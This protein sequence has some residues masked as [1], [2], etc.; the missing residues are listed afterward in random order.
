M[1]CTSGCVFLSN[2]LFISVIIR[3]NKTETSR[4]V[5]DPSIINV[6]CFYVCNKKYL[7]E[8]FLYVTTSCCVF[9]YNQSDLHAMV[10]KTKLHLCLCSPVFL[11]SLYLSDIRHTYT[12]PWWLTFFFLH[13]THSCSCPWGRF[14]TSP[15]T[16]GQ[17]MMTWCKLLQSSHWMAWSINPAALQ[18]RI[19]HRHREP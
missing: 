5:V 8:I 17:M 18:C 14:I 16:K 10:L 13:T 19:Q 7:S 6:V 4:I 15:D 11:L 1:F 9:L 2:W 3:E 12:L